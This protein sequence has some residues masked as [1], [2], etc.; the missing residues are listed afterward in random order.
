ME[1]LSRQRVSRSWLLRGSLLLL[2]VLSSTFSWANPGG[3]NVISGEVSIDT[4][5][6]GLTSV[7]NSPSAIIQWQDFSIG[8]SEITRFIQQN[9]AS[10]VLNRVVGGNPSEILG[11]LLSNGQVFLINPNGVVFGADSLVDT[12]GLVASSLNITNQDFLNG[13]YHFVAGPDTG[14]VINEGIIRTAAD[15]SIVLIAPHIENSGTLNAEGGQI[16]LAAG[17]SLTL[18]SLNNPDV[19]F[20]VQAP[21]NS[22]LNV[23]ELLANGGAVELFAGTITHSGSVSATGV[24]ID[25]QGRVSLV[26]QSDITLDNTSTTIGG[27]IEVHSGT[28]EVVLQG[29]VDGD[30]ID[31]SGNLVNNIGDTQATGD[32]SID[33]NAT[34]QQGSLSAGGDIAIATN[35]LYHSGDTSTDVAEGQAGNVSIAAAGRVDATGGSSITARGETGGNISLDSGEGQLASSATID[36]SGT[37]HGGTVEITG[38][39]VALLNAEAAESFTSVVSGREVAIYLTPIN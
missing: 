13:N 7:T 32:V 19:R 10:A 37:H 21:D 6:P 38:H 4:S 35:T 16:T 8:Q 2:T 20:Q 18:T 1:V 5:T 17:E 30:D 33:A 24:E 39:R 29:A 31:L 12:Q 23:G 3:A 34:M 26:A 14:D 11:Q 25:A 36:A 22:V 15:G 9:S 28:G 27:D